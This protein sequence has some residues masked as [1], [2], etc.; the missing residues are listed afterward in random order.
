MPTKQRKQTK[1]TKQKKANPPKPLVGVIMGSDTD[2]PVMSETAKALKEFGLPA[3]VEVTSAH[4]SPQRTHLYART[5][6]ARGLQVIIVGAGGASHLAGIVAAETNLPVIA[7]PVVTTPLAGLD[8]LYSTVQMPAGVPV[9]VMAVDKPGARN[10]AI[11]AAQIIALSDPVIA[12]RLR[13][14]KIDLARSV[15]L[16][17]AR[18]RQS[19]SR[20]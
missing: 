12:A 17:S 15:E 7:V 6:A 14:H 20:S 1:Q 3:E 16:K 10:A 5:A 2:W 8:A 9:G 13:R 19:L 18:L 11:Y 4:R